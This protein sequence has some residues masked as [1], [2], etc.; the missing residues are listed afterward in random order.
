MKVEVT[1]NIDSEGKHFL[2]FTK[3]PKNDLSTVIGT[4]RSNDVDFGLF[5]RN[6]L[7]EFKDHQIVWSNPSH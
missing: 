7:G 6:F 2:V 1:K 5:R 3:V 4:C